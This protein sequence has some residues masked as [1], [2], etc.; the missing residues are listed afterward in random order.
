[1]FS[2]LLAALLSSASANS[3]NSDWE[4][5]KNNVHVARYNN[6]L[7]ISCQGDS[8]CQAMIYDN[9]D[10]PYVQVG[11]GKYIWLDT[12][13]A[14]LAQVRF[15]GTD[16]KDYLGFSSQ[17]TT[18]TGWTEFQGYGGRD[19]ITGSSS[20]D[21]IYGGTGRDSISLSNGGSDSVYCSGDSDTVYGASTDDT[22]DSCQ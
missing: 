17:I 7:Q 15:Y 13:M 11:A 10:G 16:A 2:L 18:F 9:G 5:T 4:N 3:L 21:Y 19:S 6:V 14:D 1:M 12:A 22:L 8:S 20:T